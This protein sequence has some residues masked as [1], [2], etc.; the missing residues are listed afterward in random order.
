MWQLLNLMSVIIVFLK[1]MFFLIPTY[2]C[3]WGAG[4]YCT[5]YRTIKLAEL[6]AQFSILFIA[7]SAAF[8]IS[9]GSFYALSGKFPDLNWV[10]YSARMIQYYPLYLTYTLVYSVVIF[11]IV[12][13]LISLFSISSNSATCQIK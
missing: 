12:K 4:R 7:T 9:N 10:E 5:K 2:A 3:L 13:V 11:T 8:A 1:P 6:S